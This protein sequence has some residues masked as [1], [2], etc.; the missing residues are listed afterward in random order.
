MQALEAIRRG[1][2]NPLVSLLC[3]DAELTEYLPEQYLRALMDANAY[4]GDAPARAHRMAKDLQSL[5][6]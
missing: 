4:V 1:E 3:R 2:E 6:I 5:K